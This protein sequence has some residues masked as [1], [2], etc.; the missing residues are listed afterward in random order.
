MTVQA[1]APQRSQARANRA[2]ILA[3]AREELSRDPEV[4]LEEIARAAG[5]VRRT[6]Y[7]HFPNRQALLEALAEEATQALA[8]AAETARRS[9][10]SPA[11]ALARLVI[12]G[13]PVG[14]RY[15]MLIS[16]GRRDL[17]EQIIRDALA[18][19]R[20]A[21][22]AIIV[23]GQRDGVF[24]DHLPPEILNTAIEGLMLALLD[25]AATSGSPT[26]EAST[27]ATAVLIAV[28]LSPEIARSTAHAVYSEPTVDSPA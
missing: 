5:V 15:R 17:G 21:A 1:P 10:G 20:T 22:T 6:V 25:A 12:A 8:E 27:A 24:A 7:G 3:A 13:W 16:L 19:G 23:E 9:G 4:S 2:K 14:D 28:G 18:P 11:T 26:V